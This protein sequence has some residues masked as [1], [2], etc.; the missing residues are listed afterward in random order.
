MR[1]SKLIVVAALVALTNTGF[2]Q[3]E[4]KVGVTS[5]PG[6]VTVTGTIKTKSTVVGIEPGTRTVWLKDEKGKV[7]QLVV[8][9]EARNFDQLK[10][11]DVVTAEYTQALTVT[12]KKGGA[13]L[14]AKQNETL[15]RA[16]AGAKPG[17][18]AAREVTVMAVV[19]AVNTHSGVVTLKGPQGNSVDIV[20]QDPEQLKLI[21]K[22]DHMEVVYNEAVAVSVEPEAK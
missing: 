22:G 21:K 19:T 10:L 14:A 20:V 13:P 11:G 6:K 5:T 7:V 8:G 15:E 2:A 4:P 16:P 9:E 12:L 3:T 18:T 1:N 17:G